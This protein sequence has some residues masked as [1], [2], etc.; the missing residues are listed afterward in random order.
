MTGRKGDSYLGGHT[1]IRA[2]PIGFVEL[3]RPFKKKKSNAISD[4][5]EIRV[6]DEIEHIKEMKQSLRVTRG[7]KVDALRLGTN[8]ADWESWA[9]VARR[10]ILECKT[11]RVDDP[12]R[13]ASI[14]NKNGFR[15]R[16]GQL[17]DGRLVR[18]FWDP[19]KGKMWKPPPV[20]KAVK[21]FRNK[22]K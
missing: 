3:A 12:A 20:H 18:I 2:H 19:K 15:T 5:L 9:S 1:I 6:L 21:L 22:R 7:T 11:A 4:G 10:K 8:H 13:I 14:F 17:W 16:A